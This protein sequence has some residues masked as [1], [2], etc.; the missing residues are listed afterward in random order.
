METKEKKVLE[1]LMESLD[2][3][4]FLVQLVIK[5]SEGL[6]EKQVLRETEALKV[7]GDFL[8]LLGQKETRACQV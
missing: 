5:D 3:R 8:D 4:A 6:Q 1:D 2:L 7:P